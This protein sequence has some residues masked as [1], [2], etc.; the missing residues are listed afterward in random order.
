MQNKRTVWAVAAI[1]VVLVL[2]GAGI[3]V[4][5]ASRPDR[6]PASAPAAGPSVAPTS[7]SPAPPAGSDITGPLNLL[8]L[9]IDT[10]SSIPDWEP[11]SDAIMLL[12]LDQ[13]LESGY[14]FSLPRDLR[15]QIPPFPK[16]G[17]TGGRYKI[18]E[19]MSR[20]SRVPGSDRPNPEQGYA[21]LRQTISAYT[22]IKTFDAGAVLTF[23]GLSRLT[24]ALGGVTLKIDQKVV[25][26]HRRPDGTLRTMR[27][28]GGGYVGPQATY[29]PG[30]RTLK[31]W[32][33]I[34]YARQRYTAGGD[35]ARQRHQR[36]LVKAL[37]TRADDAGLATDTAKLQQ[38]ISALGDLLIYSGERS[39]LEYAY[40]LR[41]LKPEKLTLVGL[42]GASVTGGGGYLGEQL[43]P[44]GRDF[45]K[46]VAANEPAEFL[47][48][49]PTLV[50][51]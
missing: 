46:A 29:L 37:L 24:D 36:Q 2:T 39:P 47:A 49:H 18:T 17:F 13:S 19:A 21:L 20:G 11:H 14:L 50:H 9:G 4:A 30:T 1:A 51:K 5:L 27:R 15:V 34:D 45:L 31:G 16:A 22:G 33:A 48:E 25:S 10:R 28:G 43:Q 42:P 6:P 3:A 23:T 38:T 26:Q 40:A 8:I 7:A 41:N 12:H 32:Q 35:Y 44:L